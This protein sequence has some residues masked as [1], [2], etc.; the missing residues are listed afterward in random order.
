M[1]PSTQQKYDKP[2]KIPLK[3]DF[4]VFLCLRSDAEMTTL[5]I[6][7][8]EIFNLHKKAICDCKIPRLYFIINTR[9]LLIEIY[10]IMHLALLLL[11]H[12]AVN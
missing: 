5:I 6:D 7:R 8:F 11:Q 1:M 2:E 4:T 9:L 12:L 10:C 3:S